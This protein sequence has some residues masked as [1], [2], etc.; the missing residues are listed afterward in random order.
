MQKFY[1]D[2]T[3]ALAE[4]QKQ[5]KQN[6]QTLRIKLE[7][8]KKLF[9]ANE[10]KSFATCVQLAVDIFQDAFNNQI[11]QLLN[12]FPADHI[13]EDTGKPF[14]SGLKRAPQ[15]LEFSVD[16]PLHLEFV[17]AGA[18][19]FATMFNIPLEKDKHVVA[20]I[21]SKANKKS[22]VPK[23]I[24]IETDEKKSN[25]PIV[26]DADD[27]IECEKLVKEL[28]SLK[29]NKGRAPTPIEFEKDD[30]TNW[31]IEFMG[32]VSNLRVIFYLISGT[33]LQNRGS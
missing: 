27:E 30:P 14:W 25:E 13:I 17:Q 32:G 23:K 22:F 12:A 10:E 2:H 5:H 33:K 9:A 6:P 7:T 26:I 3:Q 21:A 1:N 31:H 19:I 11:A 8:L 24:K 20:K 28:G 4:L 18:N 15:I 29:V 16:D